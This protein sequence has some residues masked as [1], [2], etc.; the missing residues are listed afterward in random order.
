MLSTTCPERLRFMY[1]YVESRAIN[2]IRS[3]LLQENHIFARLVRDNQ[4]TIT[5]LYIFYGVRNYDNLRG[6]ID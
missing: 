1:S 6:L 4:S 2:W 5:M 3:P